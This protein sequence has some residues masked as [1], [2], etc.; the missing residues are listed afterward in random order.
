MIASGAYAAG[1]IAGRQLSVEAIAAIF[2]ASTI[3]VFAL[4]KY[5][6]GLIVR[7]ILN[8]VN[9]PSLEVLDF[10]EE[11]LDINEDQLYY[12]WM[13]VNRIVREA[14][15]HARTVLVTID[16]G[17]L[18]YEYPEAA[19]EE[20]VKNVDSTGRVKAILYGDGAVRIVLDTDAAVR[21][22]KAVEKG[23]G[24]KAVVA[25]EETLV[26]LYEIAKKAYKVT[27]NASEDIAA[28]TAYKTIL[29]LVREGVVEVPGNMLDIL[30]FEAAELRERII[31]QV[32]EE[33]EY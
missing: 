5:I 31:A 16:T 6:A 26:T 30:P 29:K 32:K 20:T 23:G 21:I 2:I 1:M 14:A 4:A 8:V 19:Y 12:A 15:P 33:E 7:A 27:Y 18:Q 24:E 10:G 3:L 22:A 28:Y 13:L 17:E 25:D 11:Y 9:E